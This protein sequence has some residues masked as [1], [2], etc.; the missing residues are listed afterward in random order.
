MKNYRQLV[1]E[2]PS[3]KVVFAFGRFQPPT[4]GHELLVKAVKK[5]AGSTADHVIF[6]SKSEDK[7]SNPLPV[8]RKV[9][10]LKRMFP[11]TNFQAA[12]NEIRT[13]I[14]AAKFLNKKYKNI[15]MVAGSDRVPEYTR[16][17][18]TYN[19]K[20]F[21]FDTVEVVSAGERD[22][23]SD[24]ASGMSG[25]KM[26]EAAKKGDFELFKK[27]VPH[28]LTDLDAKRL[29]NDI[30]KG[31]GLEI[32]KEHVFLVKDTL[33]ELYFAGEIFHVG[34]IV[35]SAGEQFEIV[36]RGTNHLLVKNSEGAL[37]SKWL[38]DVQ[39]VEDVTQAYAPTEIKFGGYTTKNLHHSEDA[40]SAFQDTI[41]RFGETQHAAVLDALVATDTYMG[42]SDMHLKQGKPP[43]DAELETWK[44]A[45]NH[46]AEHL[47]KLGELDHHRDYLDNHKHEMELMLSKYK[48]E[49]K[50]EMNED[51]SDKTLK[52]SDKIKVARIIA[53]AFGVENAETSSSP[54]QLVNT[55]LRKIK[56]KPFT[57]DSL[58][59]I[60]NML[61][62]AAEV[63]IKYDNNLVP[64]KLKEGT[65]QPNGTDKI[66]VTTTYSNFKKKLESVDVKNTESDKDAEQKEA[67]VPH[68]SKIGHSISHE[69][70]SD[71]V[72]R[73]KIKQQLGEN[74]EA[75]EAHKSKAEQAKA[76][77]DQEA[78]H[79]HMSNHHEEM[80]KWH[81]S[82]G[83]HNSADISFQKA[84]EHHEASIKTNK[85]QKEEAAGVKEEPAGQHRIQ[86]TVSDPNHTA[87][88]KRKE[89]IQKHIRVSG[90]HSEESAVKK[91]TAHYKKQGYKVHSAEHVGMV[92]EEAEQIDEISQKL[93]GD[94]YGA[95][96]KKHVEKVGVK[97][98]M[99]DRIE[100]DMGKQRKAG[101][102]RALD[103]VTGARKTNEEVA[104]VDEATTP[105]YKKAS[106]IK[107]MSAAAKQERLAREKK[108]R[109]AAAAKNEGF[110]PMIQPNVQ[111]N[112]DEFDISDDE[113][114]TM[115]NGINHEDHI[116]DLYDDGELTIVDV[117]TGEEIETEEPEEGEE[118]V[119]EE[120][121]N[122]V[123][124][125][126]ERMRAKMRFAR[127]KSK[128]ERRLQIAL[129]S[130]SNTTRLNSRSRKL[131]IKMMKQRIAK[132]PLSTLSVG[133]KERIERIIQKRKTVIDRL[134]MKLAPRIRKI[135]NDRLSH[136]KV[137]K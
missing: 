90:E 125:R 21:H 4:T 81:E 38:K 17:L 18:N 46:A 128:R 96:T 15:V 99:Y 116:M 66:D 42:L 25:T 44:Q 100:K 32:I 104:E 7:K 2:L 22:P 62:L 8:A 82:K 40:A 45:W 102:D 121:L 67:G 94:Y 29:M 3:K 112:D 13:F 69:G 93:A 87:V 80:G 97:P 51:L 84:E 92:K 60:G 63:G 73:M 5:I 65:I 11:G 20:E 89:Q 53:D 14:E 134:A 95:A 26:R 30:R 101:V 106:W 49:G 59:I 31:M 126:A 109:E 19:G 105:Y 107:K 10:Y 33:R 118:K 64:S 122:E 61:Q 124:S 123:L 50:G 28:T 91:A 78:Y 132:K 35:E 57:A 108:E 55:G 24:S 114:D 129:H 74:Y 79:H 83:R 54:E 103:R 136:K 41:K 70:E 27:G 77:G 76:K 117:D 1:K 98:N 127:T 48:E 39:L 52:N 12:N 120:A 47:T 9:Y 110:D 115:A 71:T 34:D 137:T 111:E 58:K 119:N 88:S 133:E 43:T 86:V 36:K 23:D 85:V 130:R 6:A 135:E 16:I 72:R 68:T 131:A 37:S 113:M 56:S 75:A